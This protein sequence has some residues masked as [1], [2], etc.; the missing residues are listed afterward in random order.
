[1]CSIED[2]TSGSFQETIDDTTVNKAD[3]KTL[4]F[5]TGKFYY[6]ITAEKITDEQM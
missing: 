5:V 6:D 4:V 3:V 1:M 2:F